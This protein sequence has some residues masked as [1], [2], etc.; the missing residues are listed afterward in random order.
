MTDRIETPDAPEMSETPN[1]MSFQEASAWQSG[2]GAGYAALQIQILEFCRELEGVG[3]YYPTDIFVQD[4]RNRFLG[5][6]E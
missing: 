6:G 5:G 3:G 1:Y 4:L 2:W